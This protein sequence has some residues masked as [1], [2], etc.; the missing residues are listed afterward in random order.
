MNNYKLQAR[1][2]LLTHKKQFLAGI[3]Y[4]I[5]YVLVSAVGVIIVFQSVAL[6]TIKGYFV[7]YIN[8]VLLFLLIEYY[9][10]HENRPYF[11]FPKISRYLYCLI[12]S[13]IFSFMLIILNLS[14]QIMQYIA[15]AEIMAPI[16]F[17]ILV[18][19]L[20]LRCA[21]E[22]FMIFYIVA[23]QRHKYVFHN[24]RSCLCL[25]AASIKE[26]AF[27]ELRF[28]Y[29]WV[30]DLIFSIIGGFLTFFS[31]NA[32]FSFLFLYPSLFGI[33]IVLVPYY[34]IA[35]IN[36]CKNISQKNQAQTITE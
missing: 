24:L 31:S 16:L 26:I 19:A 35:K 2:S 27:F 6:S 18:V 17:L 15:P 10:S 7:N 30:L 5:L 36:F 1:K 9:S 22:Y 25:L 34:T 3:L 33:G 32:Y 11:I 13:G 28:F 20:L 8:F 14:M 4:I 21:A 29:Y 23:S 12:L